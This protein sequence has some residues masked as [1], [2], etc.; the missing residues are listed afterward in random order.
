VLLKDWRE[1]AS[2]LPGVDALGPLFQ[3]SRSKSCG[4]AALAFAL[5]RLGDLVFEE[6][7]LPAFR[8]PDNASLLD[9]AEAA[10]ARGFRARA[11]HSAHLDTLA[12]GPGLVQI[13]HL[14]FQHFVVAFQRT[15][16]DVHLL[17]PAVG[18]I[19]RVPIDQV[20]RRW[21]GHALELSP[22]PVKLMHGS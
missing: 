22:L 6:Q 18:R 8:G 9:L 7:L 11:V 5:T 2:G 1:R 12:L 10:E 17:D 16:P 3:Q 19:L 15:G 13:L 14:D 20:E 21:S 4:A